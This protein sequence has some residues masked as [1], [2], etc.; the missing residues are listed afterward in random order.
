MGNVGAVAAIRSLTL[1]R[2]PTRVDA[3]MIE[4]VRRIQALL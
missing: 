4:E 3:T 2:V 1:V